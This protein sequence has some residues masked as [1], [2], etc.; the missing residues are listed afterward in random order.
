MA[1]THE[2]RYAAPIHPLHAIL[3]AFP[4][5]LFL[6]ALV[7]DL[8]YSATYHI[9]WANFSSWLIAGALLVGGFVLLWS[10]I[11]L[12]RSGDERSGR[13]IVYFV[14]LLVMWILGF[15]NALIH[16][17]DAWGTM[18]EGLWLSVIVTLLALVAAWVGYSGLRVRE[19][20]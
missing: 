6:A 4:L 20:R 17:R 11:E 13:H 19:V 8:A 18:P 2:R 15:I 16:A 10:L 14:T 3:L 7:S 12:I 1:V 5:S 9:Q